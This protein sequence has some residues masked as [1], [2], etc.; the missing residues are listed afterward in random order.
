[1]FFF[2]FKN[3]LNNRAK[4]IILEEE[5]KNGISS[6]FLESYPS[7]L[8]VKFML[9][10]DQLRGRKVADVPPKGPQTKSATK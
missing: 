6:I 1:M 7:E 9:K 4:T 10:C 8:E 3:S 5:K 2:S